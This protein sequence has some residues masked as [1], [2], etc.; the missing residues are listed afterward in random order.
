MV[1][2]AR[3]YVS[4]HMCGAG[5]KPM[6]LCVRAPNKGCISCNK[7]TQRRL[8]HASTTCRR[9]VHDSSA[10]FRAMLGGRTASARQLATGALHILGR[11]AGMHACVAGTHV[12]P[13][14]AREKQRA[15]AS[16]RCEEKRGSRATPRAAT[17]SV[18]AARATRATKQEATKLF[19]CGLC[20][21]CL[22]DAKRTAMCNAG[23]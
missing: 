1:A 3:W 9:R 17:C 20:A 13:C 5:N 22:T 6:R 14:P 10:L 19:A 4:A 21:M 7:T 23:Q 16:A 2:L 8:H 18:R 11:T 15:L 12:P